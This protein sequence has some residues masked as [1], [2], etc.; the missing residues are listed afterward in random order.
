MLYF[1]RE[2][3]VHKWK[4]F[5]KVWVYLTSA[6]DRDMCIFNMNTSQ[7]QFTL[8][9]MLWKTVIFTIWKWKESYPVY[10]LAWKFHIVICLIYVFPL[11]KL[12]IHLDWIS[13]WQ[14]DWEVLKRIEYLLWILSI[15][16]ELVWI[17]TIICGIFLCS[18]CKTI[19]FRDNYKILKVS[20]NYLVYNFD[21]S[22]IIQT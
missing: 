10:H 4:L 16:F 15:L 18:Y 8:S 2:N 6:Y 3:C 22:N 17:W 5:K 20:I 1:F 14:R 7:L 11:S 13:G 19:I 21:F 9:I 12:Q